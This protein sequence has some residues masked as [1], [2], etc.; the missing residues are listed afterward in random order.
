MSA[1]RV[2]PGSALAQKGAR[3]ACERRAEVIV[4]ERAGAR[5]EG[6]AKLASGLCHSVYVWPKSLLDKGLRPTGDICG[7]CAP[8]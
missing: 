4:A 5:S 3:H 8:W 1:A 7:G 6:V 2:V